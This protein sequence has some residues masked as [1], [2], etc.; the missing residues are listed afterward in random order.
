MMPPLASSG[1]AD[2]RLLKSGQPGE[3]LWEQGTAPYGGERL[4][5]FCLRGHSHEKR[6]DRRMRHREA[7]RRFRQAACMSLVEERPQSSCTREVRRIG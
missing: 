7:D 2:K 5:E 3:R 6:A 1:L 4:L